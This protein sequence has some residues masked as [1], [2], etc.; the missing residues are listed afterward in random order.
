MPGLGLGRTKR[1][2][3]GSLLRAI[4]GETIRQDAIFG[5]FGKAT[6]IT[7]G[8]HVYLRNPV[9]ADAGPLHAYTAMP[10]AGLNAWFPREVFGRVETG[11]YFGHT[12]DLPLYKIPQGGAV[13]QHHADEPSHVGRHQLFDIVA[14]PQQRSPLDD[15]ALEAHFVGRIAAHLRACEAPAEQYAR[16]GLAPL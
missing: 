10:I 1:P 7:D 9:N 4:A 16:L 15:P 12:Y 2:G 5:Y 14:D 3:Q 8:R 6:N 11:R 13:P